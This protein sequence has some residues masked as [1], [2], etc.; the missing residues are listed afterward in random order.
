MLF[1]ILS[2]PAR[3]CFSSFGW[4]FFSSYCEF[5][6]VNTDSE[7]R[8]RCFYWTVRFVL[9]LCCFLHS[10]SQFWWELWL[11]CCFDSRVEF[12]GWRSG[13][14]NDFT[15]FLYRT[16][17]WIFRGI[18]CL[19]SCLKE[20]YG[21]T[22]LVN[23]LLDYSVFYCVFWLRVCFS[24]ML[25][26]VFAWLKMGCWNICGFVAIVWIKIQAMM[27]VLWNIYPLL[28]IIHDWYV[29]LITWSYACLNG[30]GSQSLITFSQQSSS[31]TVFWKEYSFKIY[32]HLKKG[33]V[34][35]YN[36]C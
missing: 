10:G 33:A 16:N 28:P 19:P 3:V 17:A 22:L 7:I 23:I 15:V 14:G 35:L 1:S 2:F 12:Q 9:C 25:C 18:D 29:E 6:V 4:F 21:S 13:C 34:F 31:I 32:L 30:Y 11:F 24:F 36:F 8:G 20:W 26:Y 5:W 27:C